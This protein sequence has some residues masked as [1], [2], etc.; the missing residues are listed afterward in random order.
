MLFFISNGDRYHGHQKEFAFNVHWSLKAKHDLSCF[1]AIEEYTFRAH[2]YMNF[3]KSFQNKIIHTK[4]YVLLILF[5]GERI[6]FLLHCKQIR[7]DI[8]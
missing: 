6:L 7:S 2:I 5:K 3:K 1:K 4:L 8:R